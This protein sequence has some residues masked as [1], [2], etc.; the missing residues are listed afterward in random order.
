MTKLYFCWEH[1]SRDRYSPAMYFG[2]PPSKSING[3]G[4]RIA[5]GPYQLNPIEASMIFFG[6]CFPRWLTEKYPP[7]KVAA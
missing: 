1:T 6:Q 7:P 5:S 2:K 4:P 3:G